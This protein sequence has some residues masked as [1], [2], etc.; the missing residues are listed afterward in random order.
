[1]RSWLL[2]TRALG[3]GFRYHPWGSSKTRRLKQTLPHAQN[4]YAIKLYCSCVPKVERI[5]LAPSRV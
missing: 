2:K 3:H 1:M 5:W 4:R